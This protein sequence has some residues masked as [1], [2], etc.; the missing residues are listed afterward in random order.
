MQFIESIESRMTCYFNYNESMAKRRAGNPLYQ[1]STICSEDFSLSFV[2][3]PHVVLRQLFGVGFAILE[4]SKLL[5][6]RVYYEGLQKK[7]GVGNL[8]VVMS[9]TDSFLFV[10]NRGNIDKVMVTL[11]EYMDFSNFPQEH[12]LFSEAVK[13]APGY[14]KNEF[15]D[16]V[17]T[18]VVALRA[19][20]NSMQTIDKEVYREAQERILSWKL[21]LVRAAQR[22]GDRETA[23]KA[24]PSLRLL[25]DYMPPSSSSALSIAIQHEAKEKERRMLAD[26]SPFS[27]SGSSLDNLPRSTFNTAK[28]V[29]KCVKDKMPFSAYLKCLKKMQ[30]HEVLQNTLRSYEHVNKMIT[31]RKVAFS[32]FDDKRFLLCPLHSVP[33]G[34]FL[35]Q[36]EYRDPCFFCKYPEKLY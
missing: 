5:M 6:Q 10:T 17:I 31:S 27:Q 21:A 9:D 33:F 12:R 7:L 2:K 3:K 34:S 16:Q 36:P 11:K 32:S 26:S 24:D 23:K 22:G 20:T 8:A 28:G 25:P 18:E 30:Q 13:R 29:K 35:S 15:P 19:K 4:M 14:L 1:S